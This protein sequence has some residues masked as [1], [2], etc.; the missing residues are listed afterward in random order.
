M[1]PAAAW[2]TPSASSTS[3]QVTSAPESRA[4]TP[5][6]IALPTAAGTSAW[7]TIHTMASVRNDQRARLGAG[8]PHQEAQGRPVV[9]RAGSAT[10]KGRIAWLT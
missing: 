6:S 9:R 5:E 4:T 8:Q 1:M 10:G 2:I 3:D 7:L